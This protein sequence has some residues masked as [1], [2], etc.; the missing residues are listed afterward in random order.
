MTVT[1]I[2]ALVLAASPLTSRLE[3]DHFII[4][5][6]PAQSSAARDLAKVTGAWR[7]RILSDLGADG[8][9]GTRV[10]LALD[11]SDMRAVAP[12]GVKVPAWAAG[13]AFPRLNLILLKLT[14]G[15]GQ[16]T[17]VEKVFAHEFSHV[18]LDHAVG[19]KPIPRWFREGF[20]IYQSGEWSFGRTRALAGGVISGR[21]FSLEALSEQFPT[22]VR[23]VELAYAQSIDFISFLL[24]EY[25][26]KPFR[27]LIR[28]LAKDWGFF[29]AL[30]EAYDDGL[31]AIEAAWHS[32]LK[33]RFTWIPLI[34]GTATL[35]FL[36]TLVFILAYLKKRRRKLAALE[37]LD[38]EEGPLPPGQPP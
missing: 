9:D 31:F 10:F 36:A 30:E 3:S 6:R 20:A 11:L 24:G 8:P 15:S 2:L 18:A 33:M 7:Q 25:G 23:D 5:H 22:S 17:D 35:W 37:K 38:E 21:L 13:M 14:S 27:K 34:T 1:F 32:D 19:F 28:L 29:L 4:F 16:S 26:P 12:R